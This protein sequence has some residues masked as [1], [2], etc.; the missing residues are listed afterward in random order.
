MKL[1]YTII[2]VANVPDTVTFYET[3]FGLTRRFVHESNLYAEMETGATALAFAGNEA[4]EMGGF[5]VRP[6]TPKDLPAAWEICLVSDD[7]SA[8]YARAISAGCVGIVAPKAKPWG[9][10]VSYVRDLNGCLV[11]LASPVAPS[12]G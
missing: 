12:H 7:V 2:Y 8:A 10:T 6:N 3:A 9:Q 5:A 11:E 1:G 4:A